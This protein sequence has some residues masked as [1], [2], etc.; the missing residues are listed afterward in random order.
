MNFDCSC[1]I[2]CCTYELFAEAMWKKEGPWRSFMSRSQFDLF[3]QRDR[4]WPSI[5]PL[6][7]FL[8]RRVG[9][10]YLTVS[11]AIDRFAVVLGPEGFR[12]V[13]KNVVFPVLWVHA[14]THQV[15]AL[16]LCE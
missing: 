11:G 9:K 6:K 1:V 4:Y 8:V 10:L 14:H 2:D 12:V 5:F 3:R 16:N 13:E 7:L 15:F